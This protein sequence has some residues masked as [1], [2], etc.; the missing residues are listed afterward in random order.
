MSSMYLP[1]KKRKA[2]QGEAAARVS[3]VL[4]WS[5]TCWRRI[6]RLDEKA[7]LSHQELEL[8]AVTENGRDERASVRAHGD[9]H[10]LLEDEP[11]ERDVAVL[12]NKREQLYYSI[13]AE[14]D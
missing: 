13:G 9:A 8:E 3:R 5:C 10:D 11:T 1:L 4:R 2:G 6:A 14:Y 7:E 12:Y